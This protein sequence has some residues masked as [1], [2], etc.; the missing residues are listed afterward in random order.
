MA[1]LRGD[2]ILPGLKVNDLHAAGI[3]PRIRFEVGGDAEKTVDFDDIECFLRRELWWQLYVNPCGIRRQLH[4]PLGNIWPILAMIEYRDNKDG[5][6]DYH[7]VLRDIHKK[8]TVAEVSLRRDYG[9]CFLATARKHVAAY[10]LVDGRITVVDVETGKVVK[11]FESES[12]RKKHDVLR[13]G[14]GLFGEDRTPFA[15]SPAG[16]EI[17]CVVDDAVELRD[18]SSGVAHKL[19]GHLD[20]VEAVAF[21]PDG[22]ILASAANDGTLRFWNVKQGNMVHVIKD[23]PFRVNK[24]IFSTDGGRIAVEYSAGKAEIRSVELK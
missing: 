20:V 8:K 22:K 15:I 11:K 9:R 21:S 13:I 23:L 7:L 3:R 19:E 24:L 10:K 2:E 6:H 12:F 17:A 4:V 14:E 16:D 18:T 5:Y 1:P